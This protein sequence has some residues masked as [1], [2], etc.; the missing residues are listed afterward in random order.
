MT[1]DDMVVVSA[2]LSDALRQWLRARD[3]RP[4]V[5][6]TALVYETAALIALH[7]ESIEQAH[8]LVDAWGLTMKD[9]IHRLGV[10]VE[11]P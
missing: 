5:Q 4:D 9:Q 7:A 8:A 1:N 6:A 2:E 10:G 11:H 3:D